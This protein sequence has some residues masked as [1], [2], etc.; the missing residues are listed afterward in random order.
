MAFIVQS[1][2]QACT[3]GLF[4]CDEQLPCL[5]RPVIEHKDLDL[6][7]AGGEQAGNRPGDGALFIAGGDEH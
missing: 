7:S 4:S 6:D 3:N 2:S 5:G 1:C